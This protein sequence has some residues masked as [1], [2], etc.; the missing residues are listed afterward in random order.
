MTERINYHGG[1][2]M[3]CEKRRYLWFLDD[4]ILTARAA[5]VIDETKAKKR[6]LLAFAQR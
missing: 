6:G 5:R 1:M 3:F 2:S 4:L